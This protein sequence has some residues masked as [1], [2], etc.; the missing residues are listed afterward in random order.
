MD[1]EEG[2]MKKSRER[3]VVALVSLSIA[4]SSFS[5]MPHIPRGR[6]PDPGSLSADE[7]ETLSSLRSYADPSLFAM[8]YKGDYDAALRKNIYEAIGLSQAAPR[9][10]STFAAIGAGGKAI[11]ARNHDFYASPALVLFTSPSK[12]YRSVSIVDLSLLGIEAASK[13]G[14]IPESLRTMLLYAPFLPSDG[15][16]EFGFAAGTMYTSKAESDKD[17]SK[18]TV[19]S[20]EAIRFML[21]RAK[22]VGEAIGVLNGINIDFPVMPCHF[23]IADASGD[24]AVIEF[25]SGKAR[26]I[27]S[28]TG[29]QV[30]TNFQL[31]GSEKEIEKRIPD[32]R[33]EGIVRNDLNGR[34][35]WRYLTASE[36][37]RGCEGRV[38]PAEAMGILESVA[39]SERSREVWM[40]TQ[41][42]AVYEL[43][44]GGLTVATNRE[45]GSPRSF[46]L[47]PR[48]E[49]VTP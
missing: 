22:T 45:Y 38:S 34:S 2:L 18:S 23:L 24:S 3:A 30:S 44:T 37:L 27:K 17:P 40:T 12:G 20:L 29:Y 10:C 1:R 19:F 11:F 39:L 15:M 49:R 47:E 21:D 32:F 8:T 5:C 31:F 14:D 26:I 28:G 9:G 13:T 25:V 36:E 35:Y 4:I 6:S 43:G 7:A 16:N 42:S 46:A 48:L 41:W 33:K